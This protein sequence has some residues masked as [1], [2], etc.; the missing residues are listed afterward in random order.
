MQSRSRGRVDRKKHRDSHHTRKK[1][2]NEPRYRHVTIL[3]VAQ[4]SVRCSAGL[5]AD[6]GQPDVALR[7]SAAA[8][9]ACGGGIS[10]VWFPDLRT[11][12]I[13]ATVA[14]LVKF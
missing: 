1:G 10:S 7:L 11:G 3:S 8:E 9:A 13:A 5:A 2:P 6:L 4:N 14:I 12:Q